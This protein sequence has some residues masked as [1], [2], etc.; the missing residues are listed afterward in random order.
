MDAAQ[1]TSNEGDHAVDGRQPTRGATAMES[2]VAAS[3]CPAEVPKLPELSSPPL[4]TVI[5]PVF[6]EVQTIDELL[7]RVVP[8]P[9]DKE[10]LVV[11]DGSTDGSSAALS[12]WESRSIIKAY[13]HSRNHGKG[14]AI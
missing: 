13:R 7:R 12:E 10:I 4:L 5:V 6:N 11:D 1:A 3:S 9:Y 2:C 14:R 8:A